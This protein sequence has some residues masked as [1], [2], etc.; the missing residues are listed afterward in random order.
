MEIN[1]LESPD[2]QLMDISEAGTTL[3]NTSTSSTISN[4]TENENCEKNYEP[5]E[6]VT[7]NMNSM[8]LTTSSIEGKNIT[9]STNTIQ[10]NSQKLTP[11]KL[12]PLMIENEN[13]ESEE[14]CNN[15]SNFP[16]VVLS[17]KTK[18]TKVKSTVSTIHN[19]NNE[20]VMKK[21]IYRE[22]SPVSTQKLILSDKFCLRRVNDILPGSCFRQSES[23]IKRFFFP[24]FIKNQSCA[25]VFF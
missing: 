5:K 14:S 2:Y 15:V 22:P 8:Q 21:P 6:T 11:V 18:S 3:D 20:T 7:K 17:H 25:S 19:N 10:H 13:E 16:D 23:M 12:H 9:L 1:K 24:G 4:Q